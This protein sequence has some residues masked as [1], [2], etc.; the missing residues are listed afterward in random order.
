MALEEGD[1]LWMLRYPFMKNIK[2]RLDA[3]SALIIVY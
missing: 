2:I 1:K 3:E